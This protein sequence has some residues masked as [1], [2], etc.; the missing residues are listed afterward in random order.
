LLVYQFKVELFNL[1]LEALHHLFDVFKSI[2]LDSVGHFIDVFKS[3]FFD[4]GGYFTFC[5]LFPITLID[6]IPLVLFM[7]DARTTNLFG[8]IYTYGYDQGL[9]RHRDT[10]I[11]VG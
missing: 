1:D 2:F 7:N 8:N 11:L 4:F 3:I 10:Y 5:I 9:R 6:L